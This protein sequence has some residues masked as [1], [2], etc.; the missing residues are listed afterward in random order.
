MGASTSIEFLEKEVVRLQ[1]VVA[2]RAVDRD[3]MRKR[4]DE[5]ER[6][7]LDVNQALD[8]A[9]VLLREDFPAEAQSLDQKVK[10]AIL[11]L[12]KQI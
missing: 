10:E 1:V 11:V 9:V 3:Q 2:N 4:I 12:E 6:T 7:L 8:G 5:L